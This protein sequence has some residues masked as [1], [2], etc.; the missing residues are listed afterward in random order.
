MF[1]PK[2]VSMNGE[3]IDAP[4]SYGGIIDIFEKCKS[5]FLNS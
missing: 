5:L 3:I 4:A 2:N 1:P